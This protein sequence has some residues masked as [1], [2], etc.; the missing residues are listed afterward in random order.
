MY[1]HVTV[2]LR[3]EEKFLLEHIC[4]DVG[5]EDIWRPDDIHGPSAITALFLYFIQMRFEKSELDWITGNPCIEVNEDLFSDLTVDHN[6]RLIEVLERAYAEFVREEQQKYD[7]ILESDYPVVQDD[8]GMETL[9]IYL[10]WL[11]EN[12]TLKNRCSQE[13][14]EMVQR[15]SVER[16][17]EICKESHQKSSKV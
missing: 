8:C 14:V 11:D 17:E 1:A 13:E 7:Y 6:D 2:N 9:A 4:N 15:L 5:P 16:F 12:V 3:E 10:D